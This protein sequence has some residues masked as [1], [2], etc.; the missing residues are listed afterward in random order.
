[1]TPVKDETLKNV[2]TLVGRPV[3]LLIRTQEGQVEL[4]EREGAEVT[5][6]LL[7][8]FLALDSIAVSLFTL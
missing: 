1:M 4:G 7:L 8:F 6:G 5:Q 3:G 2:T